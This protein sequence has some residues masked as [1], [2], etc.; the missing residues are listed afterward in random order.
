MIISAACRGYVNNEYNIFPVHRHSDFFIWM[1][2][3]HCSYNKEDIEQGFIDYE[4]PNTYKF[5]SRIQA[6]KIAFECNQIPL[7]KTELYSEDL[8]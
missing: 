3:L 1:K 5:V 2:N 8:W 6:A 7:K 4:Y